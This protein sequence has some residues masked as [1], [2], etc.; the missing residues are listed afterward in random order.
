MEP[1]N[2]FLRAFLDACFAGDLSKTQEAIA[3]GQLT[4]E[5][6]NA[7]LKL[8]AHIAHSDIVAALF[9]AGASVSEST[10]ASHPG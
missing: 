8:A 2:A 5:N 9:D 1:N 4:A 6:L 3:T 10:V 7:G